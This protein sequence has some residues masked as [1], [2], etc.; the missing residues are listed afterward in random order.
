MKYTIKIRGCDDTTRFDM[1][2]SGKEY[3]LVKKIAELSDNNSTYRCMPTL[4]VE[5][6]EEKV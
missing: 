3:A 5:A 6:T 4:S 2:L 1:K